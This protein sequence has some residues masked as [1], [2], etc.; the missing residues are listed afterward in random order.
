MLALEAGGILPTRNFRDGSFEGAKD[1]S[2]QKMRDTILV[3]RGTCYACA[4]ACKREVEVKALGVTPKFGGPEY[5]TL[6]ASGSL[7]GVRDLEK[8]ALMNQLHAQYVLDSIST[9]AG[10]A[11]I[12]RSSSRRGNRSMQSWRSSRR[13]QSTEKTVSRRAFL[14]NRRRRSSR[15]TTC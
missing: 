8:L 12:P 7:L 11:A 10:A 5:E 3:N 9:G 4:V 6:A 2:G 1:I 15:S 14:R 13:S